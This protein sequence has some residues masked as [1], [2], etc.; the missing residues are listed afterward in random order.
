MRIKRHFTLTELL[1]TISIIGVLLAILLPTISG[2]REKAKITEAKSELSS[3]VTAVKLYE[4]TYGYL[5]LT[6][7][8]IDSNNG[9]GGTESEIGSTPY[10]LLISFL[11]GDNPREIRMLEVKET[12]GQLLDPWGNRYGVALDSDYDGDIDQDTSNGVYEVVYA[13][14][15]AW[16]KGPD[17]NDDHGE[18][19]RASDNDDIASW[20]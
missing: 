14:A 8:Y 6:A 2:V 19:D 10:G 3:L 20:E 12:L 7:S 15:A 9:S 5:P 18:N 17:G 16:S 11:H 4:S 13:S 1:L